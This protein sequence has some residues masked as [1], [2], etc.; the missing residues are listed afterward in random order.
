MSLNRY[1]RMRQKRILTSL[2]LQWRQKPSIPATWYT[3]VVW[4]EPWGDREPARSTSSLNSHFLVSS[5]PGD[6]F[7]Q[8]STLRETEVLFILTQTGLSSLTPGDE[9]ITQHK[10]AH[11]ISCFFFFF[12]FCAVIKYPDTSN[13]RERLCFGL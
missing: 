3:L 12:F 13:L 5:S 6:R 9:L 1:H 7:V 4:V 2:G 10:Q 8:D 11:F